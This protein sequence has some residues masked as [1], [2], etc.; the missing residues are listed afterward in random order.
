MWIHEKEQT[1]NRRESRKPLA[2]S[3]NRICL[4]SLE[5]GGPNRKSKICS[6]VYRLAQLRDLKVP[7]SAESEPVHKPSVCSPTRVYGPR[8]FTNLRF[9]LRLGSTALACSQTFGLLSDSGLRPSL[10]HKPSVCSPTRV[11]DPRLNR[12]DPNTA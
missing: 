2:C 9:A 7:A 12:I 11:F 6:Q 1:A 4:S 3:Q 5:L 8:L 10:V